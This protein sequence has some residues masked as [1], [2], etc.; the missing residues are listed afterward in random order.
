M[1]KNVL[2][3]SDPC[4]ATDS[5][6]SLTLEKNQ[7]ELSYWTRFSEYLYRSDISPDSARLL[8]E[9][10]NNTRIQLEVLRISLSK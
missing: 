2:K 9:K 7:F 1:H 4:N 8:F 5:L 3:F 6:L 10:F